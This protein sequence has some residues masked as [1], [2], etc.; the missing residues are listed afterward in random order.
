MP[1]KLE[2]NASMVS[3]HGVRMREPVVSEF[4]GKNVGNQKEPGLFG[5]MFPSLADTPL[6]VGDL[7]LKKLAD[8]MK[9]ASP[10]DVAG[11]NPQVPAGF[12]YLGQFIDHDMTLD[13]SGIGE[14][15]DDPLTVE[16]FR[17]P[18]LDLDSIYGLGPGASPQLYARDPA[19]GFAPGAKFLIGVAD[20]SRNVNQADPP[21]PSFPNDLPRSPQGFALIGDHRN[22]ENLVVAQ[23]HLAFLKF[24]NKVVDKLIADGVG[25]GNLFAEARKLVTWHYQWIVLFDFV[26]RLTEPGIVAKIMHDGR[27][28]YRFK[29]RPYMPT[30]FS[31]AAY[32]LGHSMVREQYS[33]NR[34]F[35]P[36]DPR[37]APA[38]LAFLFR[39]SGLSGNIHGDLDTPPSHLP[40]N[41]IIDWRRFFDLG[42][43]VTTPNF[44]F[45]H[46]RKLDPFLIP[47]LHNLP[48]G[49]GS[50][51]FRNMK[52][53][54]MMKLPSGQDVA[55][56]MKPHVKKPVL[57]DDEIASGPDGAVAKELG[58]HK[59]TP[60][61]YY[62]L[63]EA[64]VRTGGERLGPYGARLV[65][66]VFTGIV[67]GDKDSFMSQKNWKPS[68]GPV[69][70]R[71]TMADMLRFVND[72]NP[73]G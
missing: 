58:L 5:Q 32:R 2:K 70:G 44:E 14:R 50:L 12:T 31:V 34:A 40:S 67:Q 22:D 26:E 54:V 20:V 36:K 45:N 17:T 47:Q 51:P 42:T 9:D 6:K 56:F 64:Q 19:N 39:F 21:I 16:N 73:I 71:F 41:W 10:D 49:G 63:K 52:R 29:T 69:A 48:G 3:G 37:I 8:A 33:H 59:K 7:E 18:A 35:R 15:I 28:F 23:I 4:N 72:V 27:K 13:T 46:S 25:G 66:E 43:P 1:E 57:T 38:S 11:D 30:E 24:H 61:W 55:N 53:G 65:A 68:L 60:L 62:I